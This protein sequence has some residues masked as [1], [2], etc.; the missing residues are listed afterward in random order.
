MKEKLC[1]II[2]VCCIICNAENHSNVFGEIFKVDNSTYVEVD[3]PHNSIYNIDSSGINLSYGSFELY[4]HYSKYTKNSYSFFQIFP[5]ELYDFTRDAMHSTIGNIIEFNR[6][7]WR[8]FR[9]DLLL[10]K[11][12]KIA[13]VYI[14]FNANDVFS[15]M[16]SSKDKNWQSCERLIEKILSS[17]KVLSWKTSFIYHKYEKTIVINYPYILPC[18]EKRNAKWASVIGITNNNAQ[19]FINCRV[20]C[21]LHEA[22]LAYAKIN[23]ITKANGFFCIKK[24]FSYNG[25]NA[26]F[27]ANK[28]FSQ[29][30][31]VAKRGECIMVLN[32]PTKA[33]NLFQNIVFLQG[34]IEKT[35]IFSIADKKQ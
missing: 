33:D 2:F 32:L 7:D 21:S 20:L 31:V 14:V 15:F 27:F 17:L 6:G 18:I 9:A 19:L 25:W 5:K 12:E 34:I 28:N 13:L 35:R 30:A 3:F 10:K 29:I 11:T 4:V 22:M 26:S 24:E 16:V 23:S 1:F 8:G